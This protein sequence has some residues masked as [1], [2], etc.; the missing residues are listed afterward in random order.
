MKF[1]E[2]KNKTFLAPR[3]G[4]GQTHDLPDILDS[5]MVVII[6]VKVR[7]MMR[8]SSLDVHANDNSEEPRK[9]LALLIQFIDHLTRCR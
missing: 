7:H 8:S 3:K 1:C 6:R 4:T 2:S 9:P 5:H